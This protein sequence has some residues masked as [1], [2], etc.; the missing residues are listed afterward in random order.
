MS[1]QQPVAGT[2]Q[3]PLKALYADW[4]EILATTENLTVRLFRS[5][6]DE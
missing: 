2:H 6:F 3:D 1:D 5:I 4:S